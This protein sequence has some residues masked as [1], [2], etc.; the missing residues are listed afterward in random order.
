MPAHPFR[1]I[2]AM[3]LS[4]AAACSLAACASVPG[5]NLAAGAP[6]SAEEAQLGAQY[7]QQFVAEFGGAMTGPQAQYV[8]QI[9]QN[10]AAQTGVGNAQGYTVTL[11]NSPVN[12]AFA[13]PGGY[14]YVTRQMLGLMNNE[15]ELAG[16]LGHEV[17]HVVARHSARRQQNAQRNQIFGMLGQVL[18]GVLLG[19]SAIGRGVSELAST[20]PQ[21][22]TLQ[23]SRSQEIEA[24][25]L[26]INYLRS[27]GY[28]PRAVGTML[29]SIAAQA[30]LDASLQGR[31]DATIPEWASTHPNPASRVQNALQK[32]GNAAGVINRETFLNRVDG[33]LYDDDPA[34]GIIEGN[35]FIHP[36]LRLSF[37]A[38]QG[39]YM[40]N[41]TRAVSINGDSGRAQLTTAAYNG[42]LERYIQQVFQ[43]LGG[44]Q[45]QLAPQAIQRTTVNGLEAAYGTARV[46][47]GQQSVDVVVFAYQ[48]SNNQAYHFAAITPAGQAGVFSPMFNS[49]QRIT[50]AQAAEVVPRRIDVVTAQRADSVETLARRM[51]Y[52][53]AQVARFRVLNGLSGNEQLVPGQQYK[54]VVRAGR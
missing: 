31:N 20:A 10:M 36:D 54:L 2:G 8:A 25:E 49:M 43:A 3:L 22:A 24:D 47:S 37:V 28:D 7:H 53:N 46:A 17:G 39:F 29:Q 42:N 14:V 38:P 16:V 48:F 23:Y 35:T 5:A 41:G 51:G 52:S 6:I 26:G 1:R 12:N 9:G 33:M 45:Q 19:D 30:A 15:A 21:L 18:S 11:L 40:I 4:G 27:A 50:A 13:V 44:Q 34:Q 32:A